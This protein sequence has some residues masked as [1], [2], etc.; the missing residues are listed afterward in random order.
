MRPKR[1]GRGLSNLIQPAEETS[2]VE[3]RMRAAPTGS[4]PTPG[5]Q[6]IPLAR[7]RPNPFQPRSRF[8]ETALEELADSI[9]EHGVLQPVVVRATPT[10]GYELVAGER[11]L[12]AAQK[13][14]L[15]AIPALVREASDQELQTLALVENLQREDLNAVEKA[16]ALRAMMR[17]FTWTQEDVARRVG[18][19]RTTIA[20]LLRL[21]DLPDEILGM[22]EA[23]ALTGAHAR[24]V[25]QAE[26]TERR[27]VLARLAAAQGLSVREIEK[28]ARSGPTIGKRKQRSVDPYVRDLEARLQRSLSTEVHLRPRGKGGRIEIRYQDAEQLDRILDLLDA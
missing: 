28:R 22:V 27:L 6:E 15:E 25:L 18:K 2:A 17:N 7:I 13:V 24:A 10:D 4:P 11:R 16:R 23:G 5:A 20:N 12:R 8:D 19:A 21:L 26:G 14:G 1:L 9:R 3:R